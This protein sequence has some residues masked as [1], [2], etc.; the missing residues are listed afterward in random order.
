MGTE[1]L[2][3]AVTRL[4]A[5]RKNILSCTTTLMQQHFR[6]K[7]QKLKLIPNANVKSCEY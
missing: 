1:Q 5:Q 4:M 3:S 2:D 7:Q 6:L